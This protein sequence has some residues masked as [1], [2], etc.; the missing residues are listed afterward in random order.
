MWGYICMKV[1]QDW[2]LYMF[3]DKQGQIYMFKLIQTCCNYVVQM[4]CKMELRRPCMP[5]ILN[6]TIQLPQLM[7]VNV[8]NNRWQIWIAGVYKTTSVSILL[9]VKYSPLHARKLLSLMITN[10]EQ[11]VWLELTV[12]RILASSLSPDFHG[13][14][15][16]IVSSPRQTK[17]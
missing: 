8:Y 7:T 1:K 2:W 13:N 5:K 9:N 11:K 10:W 16:S 14:F 15:K 12:K 17:C 4:L 6:C 3:V